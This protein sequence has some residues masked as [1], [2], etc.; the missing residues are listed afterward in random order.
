MEFLWILEVE[1]LQVG[2]LQPEKVNELH[3]IIV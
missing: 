1:S 3:P 2:N